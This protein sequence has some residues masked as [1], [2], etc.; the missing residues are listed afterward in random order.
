MNIQNRKHRTQ[1]IGKIPRHRV[2][3]RI[4]VGLQST[5]FLGSAP[6]PIPPS[7]SV[8]SPTKA[9]GFVPMVLLGRIRSA[10]PLFGRI[11]SAESPAGVVLSFGLRS[12]IWKPYHGRTLIS[13]SF[14]AI[15]SLLLFLSFI[16]WFP[17]CD[18]GYV[19]VTSGFGLQRW[20]T[21]LVFSIVLE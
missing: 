11:L 5:S 3:T 15:L 21:V 10:L 17:F 9:L 20:R 8:G 1:S 18:F 2:V 12:N 4:Y 14:N 7:P 19:I 13:I 6:A 16:L